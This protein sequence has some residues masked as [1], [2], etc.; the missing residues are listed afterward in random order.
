MGSY[1]EQADSVP[2]YVEKSGQ[3]L[4]DNV[5]TYFDQKSIS[6]NQIRDFHLLAPVALANRQN[7]KNV[8]KQYNFDILMKFLFTSYQKD[9]QHLLQ[10]STVCVAFLS[11]C[12]L[13][14]HK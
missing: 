8:S 11:C 9:V 14:I 2:K 10:I 6:R 13:D 1:K 7:V 3:N 5:K 12:N 4:N